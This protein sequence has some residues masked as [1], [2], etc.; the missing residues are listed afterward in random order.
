MDNRIRGGKYRV[1]QLLGRGAFAEVYLAEDSAGREYACKVSCRADLLEREASFQ[2]G[3]VHLLFP[4]VY[5]YWQEEQGYLLMEYVRG[6]N[7]EE[8]VRRK[9]LFSDR[10]AAEIGCRLAEG[11]GYLHEGKEP[12]LF[13]DVKPAN[14]MLTPEGDVRLVD[15]GC[16]CPMGRNADMA[17]T[18]GFGAPEQFVPEGIQTVRTDVYGLGRTIQEIA[19]KNCV[20]LLKKVTEK[21]TER[22][23]EDRLPDMWEAAGLLRCCTGKP[24]ACLSS[25]G[26]AILRGDIKVLKSVCRY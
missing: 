23:A 19:G 11:L 4:A 21:C 16:V 5:D 26:R 3:A 17:G 1:R 22:E 25:R 10:Q 15:F 12:L 9:G 6:G 13:R 24:G 2:R 14:V 8:V 7:L 20:G 18:P